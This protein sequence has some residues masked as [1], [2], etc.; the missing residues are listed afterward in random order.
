MLHR[1]DVAQRRMQPAMIVE[2]HSVHDLSPGLLTRGESVSMHTGSFQAA[3]EALGRGVVPAVALSAH[4]RPYGPAAQRTLE[5]P[6]AILSAPVAVEDQPR[7]WLTPPACTRSGATGKLCALSV[8]TTNLRRVRA[9]MPCCC[10]SR[11]TRSLPTRTPR[12]CSCLCMR[13]HPHSPLNWAWM[14]RMR[15]SKA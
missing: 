12:A 10:M 5:L 9:R 11:R 6:A 4:G 1:A 14:A 2:S 7:L 15:A 13:G 3:K 8:V